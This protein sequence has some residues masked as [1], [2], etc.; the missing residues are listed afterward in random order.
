MLITVTGGSGTIG[1]AL[2][3]ALAAERIPV[4]S[5]D[6]RPPS[7]PVRGVEFVHTDLRDLP[8]TVDATRGSGVLIHLAVI[9]TFPEVSEHNI[10]ATHHVLEAAR[11]NRIPRVVLASSHH[12][13]GLTPLGQ[14]VTPTTPNRPDS[15]YAIS[16]ITCESLGRLYAH[17]HG[18]TVIALC[19]G[20][21]RPVPTE[22]R[23]LA[24]RPRRHHPAPRRRRTRDRT[25]PDRLRHLQQ[26]AAL[27]A[28]RGL[29][30][31]RLSPRR[32][33]RRPPA[34]HPDHRPLARRQLRHRF[35]TP[36]SDRPA[37]RRT[38]P[39]PARDHRA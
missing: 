31:P 13:I 24:Q 25:L 27:V 22:P 35:M 37:N 29:G 6:L 11:R 32:H 7:P 23:H 33:R 15:F 30:P 39:T 17:K 34:P 38:R 12:T 14:T 9:T 18:L 10:T 2:S 1:T 21:F 19:I 16:K 5:V 3:A 20:S 8:A 28:P 4:R 26:P 36:R